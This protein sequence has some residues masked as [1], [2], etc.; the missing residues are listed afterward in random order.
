MVLR[1]RSKVCYGLSSYHAQRAFHVSHTVRASTPSARGRG[2]H[3]FSA[4]AGLEPLC[5][6]TQNGQT[7]LSSWPNFSLDVQDLP[8]AGLQK[9]LEC[10]L[11][12]E[13]IFRTFWD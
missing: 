1:A 3:L 13:L 6:R 9:R 10:W 7:V 2:A 12:A 4:F 5:H 11:K 8:S